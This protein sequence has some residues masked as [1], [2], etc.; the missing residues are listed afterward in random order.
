MAVSHRQSGAAQI[1][2]WSAP[3]RAEAPIRSLALPLKTHA[4]NPV[5]ALPPDQE[6]VRKPLSQAVPSVIEREVR[7]AEAVRR[8]P[9]TGEPLRRRRPITVGTSA[10]G[11][12]V[13]GRR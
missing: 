6:P 1:P 10:P 12:Q 7:A 13:V 5:A 11:V 8:R 9:G 3:I 2:L 4:T